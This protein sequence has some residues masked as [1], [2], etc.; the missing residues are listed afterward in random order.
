MINPSPNTRRATHAD[1]PRIMEIRHAVRGNRLFDPN[2]VTA[3]DCIAFIDRAV[4]WVWTDPASE[5]QGFSA[6]DPRDGSIWALSVDPANEGRGIGRALLALACSTVRSAGIAAATLT[7]EP[8][9]RA[10]RFYRMN[11]WIETGR[12]A[13]GDIVFQRRIGE[14]S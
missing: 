14:A 6:S 3:A 4:M 13:K 7:T 9:T 2:S 5:V 11:G 12:S 8:G 10:E 1:V